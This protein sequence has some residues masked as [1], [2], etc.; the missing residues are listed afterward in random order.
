MTNVIEFFSPLM[1]SLIYFLRA[2]NFPILK[3]FHPLCDYLLHIL[4]EKVCFN[5]KKVHLKQTFSWKMVKKIIFFQLP[6]ST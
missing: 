5:P 3:I 6:L 1:F 4:K 2:K